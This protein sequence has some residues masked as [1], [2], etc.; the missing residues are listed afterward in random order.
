M[1]DL[2]NPTDLIIMTN[3]SKPTVRK[4]AGYD[5]SEYNWDLKTRRYKKN[6]NYKNPRRH[7]RFIIPALA[8][9]AIVLLI[10]IVFFELN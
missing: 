10:R 2:V 9:I 4:S 5:I 3:K 6:P 8:I 1:S 7:P